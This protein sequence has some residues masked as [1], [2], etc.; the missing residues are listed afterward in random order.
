[1]CVIVCMSGRL[2]GQPK[3]QSVPHEFTVNWVC[4]WDGMKSFPGYTQDQQQVNLEALHA[5]N[6]LCNLQSQSDY[7][8]CL[9]SPVPSHRRSRLAGN[10]AH[11]EC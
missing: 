1:M 8:V 10:I 2:T 7:A 3:T 11:D 9:A 4:E 5:L 6:R